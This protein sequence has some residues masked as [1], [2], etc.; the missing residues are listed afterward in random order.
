MRIWRHLSAPSLS[1]TFPPERLQ[2]ITDAIAAGERRHDGQVMFAVEADLPWRALWQG[3][4]PRQRAE[5]AFAQLRTWDTEH[6]NGVLVYLLLADHA[7][8][9]VA[10]RGLRGKVGEAQWQAV[11][12]HMQQ[13]LRDGTLQ[14][15]VLLAIEEVSAI[16][17]GH[18]PPG[19]GSKD[20]ALP[21]SPQLL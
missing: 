4:T 21:D 11:C 15:A 19:S 13:Q 10:D 5:H 6:N 14:D 18:Y 9:L 16:L 17:A 3:V 20:D 8:E 12:A 2:A 1:R 7:I